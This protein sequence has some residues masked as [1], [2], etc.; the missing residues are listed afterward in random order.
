LV[1]G[2]V[3]VVGVA[4]EVGA[5]NLV[6]RLLDAVLQRIPIIGSVYGTSK[7][8]VSL[9][10][11]REGADLAGMQAVFCLFGGESGVG[12]LALLVSPERFRLNGRDY[13]VVIVPTAPV[14]VGGGLLFVP[15]EMV[16][17]AR[18]SVEALMSIYVSMGVTAPQ[19]LPPTTRSETQPT[20]RAHPAE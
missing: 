12:V 4:V 2:L 16:R 8:L 10:D 13:L 5:K 6:Q 3:F 17:P 11:K 15:A 18:V 1:L 20:R 14:P 7:Q 19:L 9:V